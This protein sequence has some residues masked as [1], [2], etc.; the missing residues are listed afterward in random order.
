MTGLVLSTTVTLNEQVEVLPISS[1]AVYVTTVVPTKK[2]LPGLWVLF[3]ETTPQ[4]PAILGAV[5]FTVALH[6]A[7][8][9]TVILVGQPVMTG[10]E[11]FVT[12]T[13]KE[14]VVVLP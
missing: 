10:F 2:M 7:L 14:Q 1:V 11:L 4:F 6:E 12:V 9:G 3:K 8:A 5:Q 13:V